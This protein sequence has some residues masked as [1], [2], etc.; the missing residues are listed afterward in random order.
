[1]AT[2]SSETAEEKMLAAGT[3]AKEVLDS[4]DSTDPEHM[5]SE[6]DAIKEFTDTLGECLADGAGQPV[7]DGLCD[8]IA[9]VSSWTKTNLKK[10]SN[11]A[12]INYVSSNSSKKTFGEALEDDLTK[13]VEIKST[14][15]HQGKSYR[16]EFSNGTVET[17]QSKDKKYSHFSWPNFLDDY[18]DATGNLPEEPK[19]GRR[20]SREWRRFLHKIIRKYGETQTTRGAR[21]CAL[22]QLQNYISTTA[23]YATVE[24]AFQ[25]N[26]VY[27][28]DDPE[29]GSPSEI[30]VLNAEIKKISDDNEVNSMAG[31]QNELDSRD[32][33]SD[34]I[35]GVSYTKVI[36][37]HRVT[38][39]RLKSRIA[40][41]AKYLQEIDDPIDRVQPSQD[42]ASVGG[43]RSG[44]ID[45]LFDGGD[46]G[47]AVAD[48][49]VSAAKEDTTADV[50]MSS[51]IAGALPP[52]PDEDD[53]EGESTDA[54]AFEKAFG[55]APDE[56]RDL[57]SSPQSTIDSS[58]GVSDD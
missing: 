40:T 31:F 52:G 42:V 11:K 6:V 43:R 51:D 17:R 49:G 32:L 29:E 45:S 48:G 41:P 56:D 21:T 34:Q 19:D 26:G 7:A 24:D 44:K 30:W 16:W 13:V 28:D 18:Y 20:E 57:L 22:D 27:I 36:N 8:Q 38:F 47:G 39:W 1:M 9:D 35:P 14:D 3:R 55:E 15:H 37:N 25:A 50:E 4:L 53:E 23:A 46:P 58:E 2:E 5:N 33:A 12:K 54:E 10:A